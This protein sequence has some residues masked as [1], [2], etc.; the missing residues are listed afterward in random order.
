[1]NLILFFCF[2]LILIAAEYVIES[3][4]NM[5][6]NPKRFS[7]SEWDNIFREC[8]D[9]KV[10]VGFELVHSICKSSCDETGL[11]Q[12]RLV[13]QDG[14][15]IQSPQAYDKSKLWPN[16]GN[17]SVTNDAPNYATMKCESG[18]YLTGFR[19]RIDNVNFKSSDD[20]RGA[21]N[22]DM[23]C[24][25]GKVLEG[26]ATAWI[27]GLLQNSKT[28]EKNPMK[29]VKSQHC[30]TGKLTGL[31]GLLGL[32]G[33]GF[34][35]KCPVGSVLNMNALQ[36]AQDNAETSKK[37]GE[38]QDWKDCVNGF[39]ISGLKGQSDL[40]AFDFAGL[41]NIKFKCKPNQYGK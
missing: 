10:A 32:V 27:N 23:R 41:I 18:E 13:C 34:G 36:L 5:S 22:I 31:A 29:W 8:P 1:M 17:S 15:F 19:Y 12:I 40:I 38:W 14:S 3:D 24:S 20:H 16:F 25:D 28:W 30:S 9:D 11:H 39:G 7:F 21:T 26:Y 37:W 4:H 2:L 35:L 6:L 33:T